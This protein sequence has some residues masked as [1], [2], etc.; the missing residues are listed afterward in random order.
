M[1]GKL[2]IS[3]FDSIPLWV[4]IT[5]IFICSIIGLA[6][7]I[8]RMIFY[9]NLKINYRPIMDGITEALRSGNSKGA[10]A[11][12][13]SYSGPLIEMINSAL[14]RWS[15]V[16]DK[17]LFIKDLSEEAVRSIERFAGII[18][19]ISTISPML[20]L[21]GTVTGMMKSFSGLS[22]YGPAAQ[23]LLAQGIT[24]ALITTA[25]GLMV[26]IPAVTFYNFMVSKVD[27]FMREVEYI[28]NSLIAAGDE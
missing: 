8:E 16:N 15:D 26:A 27:F 13:A 9:K 20:G 1:T 14:D 18:S 7:F 17:E 2:F 23:D 4:M 10:R 11:L 25:L 3:I 19:T 5:P 6:V 24:E 21:L 28:A 12:C 22:S